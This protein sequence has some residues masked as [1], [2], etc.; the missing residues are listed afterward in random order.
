[1]K[2]RV[3][4][5]TPKVAQQNIE[6]IAQLERDLLNARTLSQRIADSIADFAGSIRFAVLHLIG[7][8]LWIVMNTGRITG[9]LPFDPYPNILLSLV[10]SCEAVLLSTFVLIKQNR[11]SRAADQ[12]AH[13]NLQIDLLAEREVTKILQIQQLMCRHL[14]VQEALQDAE[15]KDLSTD[16]AVE[17]IATE[18]KQSLASE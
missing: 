13:L 11:M 8:A 10:V 5:E 17:S 6:A 18:V 14:G 4:S 3:L 9:V 1:M 2:R 7:F 12:R 15:A 16:T